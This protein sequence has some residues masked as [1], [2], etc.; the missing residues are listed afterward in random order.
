MELKEFIS[1]TLLN[2]SE[3]VRDAQ[4]SERGKGSKFAPFSFQ[5][6]QGDG[7]QD[8]PVPHTNRLHNVEFDL[9]VTVNDSA[10]AGGKISVLGIL[11]AGVEARKDASQT[12]ATRIKFT[13]PMSLSGQI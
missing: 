9:A 5:V 6:N 1:E 3:G 13:I 7:F 4:K 11:G 2:I 10:T 8:V 12:T